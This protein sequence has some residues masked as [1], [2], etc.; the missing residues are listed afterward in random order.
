MDYAKST[1]LITGGASGIGFAYARRLLALGATV[2]VCGRRGEQLA[3]AKIGRA[4]V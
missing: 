4:H 3:W 2:A 1:V